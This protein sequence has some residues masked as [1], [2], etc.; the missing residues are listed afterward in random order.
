MELPTLGG[1]RDEQRA[2][3]ARLRRLRWRLLWQLGLEFAALA[4]VILAAAAAIL[5]F[6]DWWFRF[7]LAVRI[8]LLFMSAAGVAAFLGASA[9]RRWRSS[10]LDELSLA[11]TLDRF[12]PGVGQQ[13]AD[14]LQ[15][16]DLADEP[17][18]TT[19]AAMVRLAVGRA[20]AAL[21]ESDWHS[22]WNRRR[23]A[24]HAG[25]LFLGLLV[26]AAA[27][28]WAPEAARLSVARWLLGSRERWPQRT[29]L[30]V[31]GLDDRGRIAAPRDEPFLVEVRSDLPMVE[32]SGGRW[33]VHGRG[34]PLALR[35]EPSLPAKPRAVMVRERTAQGST[36]SG[37]MVDVG[38]AQFRFEFPPSSSRSTFTLAGGDDWLGPVT[39][40]RVD[41]PSLAETR[42]RVRE[43][44][45]TYQGFR[46]VEDPRQHLLFL[47]DTEVELTL[48]GNEQLDDTQ[49]KVQPETKPAVQRINERTFAAQWTLRQAVTLEIVLKFDPDGPL[50]ATRLS[51]A[52][53]SEGPGAAGH[54]ACAWCQQSCHAGC[55]ASAIA[56]R[57][58]RLRPGSRPLAGRSD[59]QHR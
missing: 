37:S 5:V 59:V 8:L 10:R 49:L 16:P 50:V 19:S 13:I 40:E 24:M 21:A 11:L 20:C 17:A 18:A 39:L 6:F 44:G 42:L 56:G 30:T 41:R 32:K 35:R 12:R 4:A 15:L 29:Y 34:E 28:W 27:I 14:V 55:H 31:M 2:L 45:A 36:R 43:P 48:V 47:P 58:R 3:R 53:H 25:T 22:L 51:V 9:V 46:T 7:G 23:T 52:G 54:V 26:P 1:L 57:Y 38:P 33:I